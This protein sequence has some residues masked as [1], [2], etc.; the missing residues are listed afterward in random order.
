M[1]NSTIDKVLTD[2]VSLLNLT[3]LWTCQGETPSMPYCEISLLNIRDDNGFHED[4]R[5]KTADIRFRVFAEDDSAFSKSDGIVNALEDY[6]IKATLK[7]LYFVAT[8]SD[9]IPVNYQ[10]EGKH[11]Y[12]CYVDIR[13][14]YGIEKTYLKVA[15]ISGEFNGQTFNINLEDE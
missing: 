6:N 1:I 11:I 9:V 2:F 14:S 13:F 7:P 15:I 12:S 10:E 4:N 5:I 3:P 8:I